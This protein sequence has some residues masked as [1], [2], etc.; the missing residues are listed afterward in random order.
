MGV[1]FS[2]WG[3]EVEEVPQC[4][5]ENGRWELWIWEEVRCALVCLVF[6][7]VSFCCLWTQVWEVWVEDGFEPSPVGE[8]WWLH[9]QL[10]EWRWHNEGLYWQERLGEFCVSA[11]NL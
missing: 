6:C 11:G 8:G 3:W 9:D 2:S 4:W 1:V 5:L 7:R 10:A